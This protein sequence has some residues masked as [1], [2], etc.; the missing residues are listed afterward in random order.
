[1]AESF[2][3]TTAIDYPNGAPHMGHAYEKVIADCYARWYRLLG[4]E[5]FF[6][7]GTDE[8]GQKLI[9]AAAEAKQETG[10]YVDAQVES[11]RNL[12]RDLHISNDDFIRTTESRHAKVATELWKR[13]EAK[14]DIYF[15]Q[16]EGF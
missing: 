1:M 3:I 8:N 11:F 2:Y 9:K 7:T 15:G 12:C 14:G 4:R 10:K 6:L 16:Y 5:V 13:C